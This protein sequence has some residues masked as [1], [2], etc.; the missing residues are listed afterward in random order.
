MDLTAAHT[1]NHVIAIH[2]TDTIS[3]DISV[4]TQAISILIVHHKIIGSV[5]IFS[6]FIVA[7]ILT[8]TVDRLTAKHMITG[9]NI[10][11][12]RFSI[13]RKSTAFGIFFS[14]SKAFNKI[15]IGDSDIANHNTHI[16]IT[17][18]IL[19]AIKGIQIAIICH[20]DSKAFK[21]LTYIELFYK[22]Y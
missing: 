20:T 3:L 22:E 13:F 8:S 16:L 5:F 2:I 18:T 19:I 7:I 12:I 11:G 14:R 4:A 6:Q 21:N 1:K 10:I 17:N 9:E 15:I